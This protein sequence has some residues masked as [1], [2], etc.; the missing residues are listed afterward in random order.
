MKKVERT[1]DSERNQVIV[2]ANSLI[3]KVRYSLSEH[4]Q[5]VILYTISKI[6]PDDDDFKQY[7]FSLTE[8]CDVFGI[9]RDTNNYRYFEESI[10]T[11]A[12]ASFWIHNGNALTLC[13]W[14]TR[15]EIDYDRMVVRIRF[16]DVLRPYL[17][18]LKSNFTAYSLES[19][20]ALNSKYS[21]RLYE[22]L[23]SYAFIEEKTFDV[24]ELREM[25]L[26]EN[27]TRFD[28]FK[29]IVIERPVREIN[30]YT[31]IFVEYTTIK[32][33]H[34]IGK[35]SFRIRNKNSDERS[36]ARMRRLIVVDDKAKRKVV[37]GTEE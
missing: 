10:K 26:V 29:K 24:S 4:Q 35:I 16:D 30:V 15:V 34:A 19:T 22:I 17:L 36:I 25:L 5:K 2:K 31:D 8:M 21:I 9:K 11:L 6:L 3:Q 14:F 1:T 7:E 32:V 28:N 33:G 23:K 12:D 13:R 27:N 18:M 37:D 20:L